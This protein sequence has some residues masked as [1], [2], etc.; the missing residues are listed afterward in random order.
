MLKRTILFLDKYTVHILIVVLFSVFFWIIITFSVSTTVEEDSNQ[1]VKDF[2]NNWSYEYGNTSDQ[3]NELPVKLFV[4]RGTEYKI[5][6]IVPADVENGMTLAFCTTRQSGKV[7]IDGKCIAKLNNETSS[8]FDKM[9]VSKVNYIPLKKE[10]ANKKIEIKL[11]SYSLR[12]SGRINEMYYGQYGECI[13]ACI[14]SSAPIAI[15]YLF[16]LFVGIVLIII[17]LF[18][19]GYKK[20]YL[21]LLL[22]GATTVNLVLDIVLEN[23]M[24]QSYLKNDLVINGVGL[25]SKLTLPI[26]YIGYLSVLTNSKRTKKYLK[27]II[28][29]F[30]SIMILIFLFIGKNDLGLFLDLYYCEI[31]LMYVATIILVI[32][33]ICIE[34]KYSIIPLFL[35][36]HIFMFT[37]IV[38][39]F[40]TFQYIMSY[41]NFGVFLGAGLVC[42]LAIM[43]G[44][45]INRIINTFVENRRIREELLEG[46]VELM[47]SQIQPHFIYNT[48]NSIQALIEIDSQKASEMI[49]EFSK[50]LRTHVDTIETEGLVSFNEE[51]ESIKTYVNIELLRFPKIK[52]VYD[53]SE[54]EFLLPMLSIQPIVENAIRHG[55]S[56]KI[57]GGTVWI[58]TYKADFSYIIEVIDDGVGFNQLDKQDARSLNDKRSVGIKNITYRLNKLVNAT[59]QCNSV[60]GEGTQVRVDIPIKGD[61]LNENYYS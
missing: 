31:I 21:E 38:E 44:V 28:S 22:L 41:R 9:P 60:V 34:Y 13:M 24:F 43:G 14:L 61:A 7:Y 30:I 17:F 26:I 46:R 51:L 49:Y 57:S 16:I 12:Y 45:S 27:R 6:N 19:R 2:N 11:V 56:K 37:I 33:E 3:L 32:S 53:I 1:K 10:Y 18:I 54:E 39:L 20:Q 47:I 42:S 52:V 15:L 36:L 4:K 58:K 55:V 59:V 25:L 50:Y 35:A 23:N 48:L 8:F 40:S 29:I 5:S